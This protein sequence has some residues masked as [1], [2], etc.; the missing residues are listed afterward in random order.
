MI[1]KI[2]GTRKNVQSRDTG[3]Y[4]EHKTQDEDKIIAKIPQ[5]TKEMINTDLTQQK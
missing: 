5:I 1:E 3:Q 4:C 2:K